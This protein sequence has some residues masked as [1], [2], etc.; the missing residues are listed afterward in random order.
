MTFGVIG[1]W[2][3]GNRGVLRGWQ[4]GKTGV[5]GGWQV[6]KRGCCGVAGGGGCWVGDL[7]TRGTTRPVVSLIKGSIL[8]LIPD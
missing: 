4:V 2:Q 3:V 1:G 6:G 7:Q 5:A 8:H